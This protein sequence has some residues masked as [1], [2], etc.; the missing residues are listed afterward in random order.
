MFFLL[1]LRVNESDG[2]ESVPWAN[3]LLIAVNV[4]IFFLTASSAG[5]WPSVRGPACRPFS[6]T[7]SPTPARCI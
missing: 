3:S 2:S 5:T 7:V 4:L 1:P 6:P